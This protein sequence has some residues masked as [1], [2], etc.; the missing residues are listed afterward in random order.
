MP[1]PAKNCK[2]QIADYKL[3]LAEKVAP[4]VLR[5]ASS[6]CNL[7]F[8]IRNLQCIG[9]GAAA[10]AWRIGIVVA[11][12]FAGAAWSLAQEPDAD[13]KAAARH[14]RR[15]DFEALRA[16]PATERDR[17]KK[18]IGELSDE[19][20]E[21]QA[22]LLQVA[23]RY[24]TWLNR[25]P[26]ADRRL[27]EQAATPVERIRKIREIRERQWIATLTPAERERIEVVTKRRDVDHARQTVL[28]TASR[29]AGLSGAPGVPVLPPP[30]LGERQ[31]LLAFFKQREWQLELE[32]TL[33][34]TQGTDRQEGMQRE[35]QRIR[36][37]LLDPTRKKPISNEDRQHL[38]SVPPDD[39]FGY[40]RTLIELAQKYDVKLPEL[41]RQPLLGQGLPRVPV[42]ELL[43]FARS[44]LSEA[45][46]K[47]LETR[48]SQPKQRQ[49]A[50]NELTRLYWNAH[51][52]KL[53]E[54]RQAE[55]KKRKEGKG[56]PE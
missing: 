5:R 55:G 54:A 52:S 32:R 4:R 29:V 9:S 44:Q 7:Q 14:D 11:V 1:Q 21:T 2:L 6:I 8:A 48:L 33:A 23:Q 15:R 50:I 25:L 49:Q 46:Q 20:P 45:R 16:L 10:R 31:R 41:R 47:E 56:G 26:A 24:V 30:P 28:W 37:E 27:V 17:I 53:Q 3:R 39:M 42:P 51:P 40:F 43:E 34:S 18:V 35:L 22:R 38:M 13:A 12:L 19:D 36:K